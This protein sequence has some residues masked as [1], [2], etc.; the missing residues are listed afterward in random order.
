MV[1]RF[2]L[3]CWLA[4]AVLALALTL[5]PA[6]GSPAHVITTTAPPPAPQLVLYRQHCIERILVHAADKSEEAVVNQI[7][8]QCRRPQSNQPS[9]AAGSA[10]LSCGRPLTVRPAP[11]A[12]RVAGCLGG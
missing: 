2:E 9:S 6:A 3:A 7:N 1:R 5:A 8:L 12:R 4:A 10:P 11:V